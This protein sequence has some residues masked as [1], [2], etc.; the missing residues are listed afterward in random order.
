MTKYEIIEDISKHKLVEEIIKN[1]IHHEDDEDLKDL[2]QDIY[3]D[4]YSKSETLLNEIYLNN[5]IQYFI[6]RMVYNNVFSK[7]SRYYTKY[8]KNLKNKVNLNSLD[9]D[10]Y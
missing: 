6:A 1:N 8:K 9:Y 7:T 10:K 2:A 4:L 3:I 5:K